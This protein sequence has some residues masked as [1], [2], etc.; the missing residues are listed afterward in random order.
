MARPRREN[1]NEVASIPFNIRITA[2]EKSAIDRL[3]ERQEDELRKLGIVA[4]ASAASLVRSW[5]QAECKRTFGSY[6]LPDDPQP[7]LPIALSVPTPTAWTKARKQALH[8]R[9]CK[10]IEAKAIGYAELAEASGLNHRT[11]TVFKSPGKGKPPR[12]ADDKCVAL[13]AA[14]TSRGF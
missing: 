6:P 11:I 3:V 1:R 14:L 12:L 7:D 13:D 8:K 2:S 10:A 4:K 9:L 5:L